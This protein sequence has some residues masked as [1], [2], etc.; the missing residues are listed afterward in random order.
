M[1]VADRLQAKSRVVQR[2]V[3]VVLL[4]VVL[5]SA[6]LVVAL[7]LRWVLTSQSGWR[8]SVRVELARTRGEAAALKTLGA[9]ASSFPSAAIW[10]RVYGDGT[11]GHAGPAVQQDVTNLTASSGM[12]VQSITPMPREK[13][14][15]LVRY[16]VRLSMTGTA[17][18]FQAF[19]TQLRVSP[20]YLRV[21]RL[22]V[23]SPQVQRPEENAPLTIVADVAGF[24][25]ERPKVRATPAT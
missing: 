1:T 10:Q 18:R 25:A 14:G 19:L 12:Q 4:P 15:P 9:R 8:E 13:E 22:T 23:T 3:A 17:D 24:A 16:T 11:G 20:R 6:G 5:V 21:E 7:P 2:L